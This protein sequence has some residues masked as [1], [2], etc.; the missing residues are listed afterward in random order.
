MMLFSRQPP[1][2]K[3]KGYPP[4]WKKNSY[5]HEGGGGNY[6][7]DFLKGFTVL[8]HFFYLKYCRFSWGQLFSGFS[9]YNG[10]LT[11]NA[12]WKK[13]K[14]YF[15]NFDDDFFV[16]SKIYMLTFN[17][18]L[19]LSEFLFLLF[20]MAD[21]SGARFEDDDD[22]EISDFE[23]FLIMAGEEIFSQFRWWFFCLFG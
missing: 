15:P 5:F 4:F 3:N 6:S 10:F 18:Y 13:K 16:S 2:K 11:K 8:F 7:L 17:L 12:F 23:F 1:K 20:S 22:D 9:E 19:T 21:K 14:K